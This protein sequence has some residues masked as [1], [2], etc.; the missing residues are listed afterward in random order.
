MPWSTPSTSSTEPSPASTT[1]TSR[2]RSRAG[3]SPSTPPSPV[4]TAPSSSFRCAPGPC[5]RLRSLATP[6]TGSTR[7]SS[8]PSSGGPTRKVRC[9]APAVPRT[10]TS[11]PRGWRPRGR[12]RRRRP[13]SIGRTSASRCRLC[14]TW[15]LRAGAGGSAPGWCASRRGPGSTSSNRG[16]AT[17]WRPA[18]GPRV[19]RRRRSGSP[20]AC[21]GT[22]WTERFAR[23]A[24]SR[25]K[26]DRDTS[27]WSLRSAP[28]AA[29]TRWTPSTAS[30]RRRRSCWTRRRS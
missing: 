2:T 26:T 12:R 30:W 8:T 29:G 15:E 18:S 7:I 25:G 24:P 4:R 17:S 5:T 21:T 3:T 10:S 19:W 6:R 1:I 11:S 16:A 23:I 27:S 9:E 13:T 22:R 28:T 14:G 20:W